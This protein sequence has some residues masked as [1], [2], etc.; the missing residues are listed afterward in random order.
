M[1]EN[2]ARNARNAPAIAWSTANPAGQFQQVLMRIP[3]NA[4]YFE[5]QLGQLAHVLAPGSKLYF[6]GM[7]KH[8]SANT[9]QLIERYF[10]SV[11]RHRGRGKARLF[12]AEQNAPASLPDSDFYCHYHCEQLGVELSALPNVFSRE[13]LDR[14]TRLLLE[15]V[16]RLAPAEDLADLACG[17]G[18]LGIAAVQQGL[19]SAV[20]FADESAMA[21]ASARMNCLAI[22]KEDRSLAFHHGDGLQGVAQRFDRIL[23]NPPFHLG[24]TV[25]DYA[26]RRLLVQCTT[27]LKP[28]GELVLVANRHLPYG[29]TLKKSFSHVEQ[30]A[31]NKKFVVWKAASPSC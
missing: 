7:D 14:G 1:R 16:H 8:L 27:S 13:R 26:G 20:T 29:E 30:L 19:A 2:C 22:R 21:I 31:C 24:H 28:G 10:G 15:N 11:Q 6:A 4:A 9:A 23:C 18:V 3:K 25:D 5:Y 17:N 12:S